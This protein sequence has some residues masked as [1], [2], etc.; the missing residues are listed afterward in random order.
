MSGTVSQKE[1]PHKLK[2]HEQSHTAI[3]DLQK[4]FLELSL[5]QAQNKQD[6][7]KNV[8]DLGDVS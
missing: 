3:M 8:L 6:N 7:L 4:E 1:E 5:R 2:L